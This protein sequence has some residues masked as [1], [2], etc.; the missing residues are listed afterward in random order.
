M[1]NTSCCTWI[2][3][4]GEVETQL[5]KIREKAHWLPLISLNPLSFDLSSWLPSGL[6]SWLRTILRTR[7]IVLLFILLCKPVVK[8]CPLC[9]SNLCKNDVPNKVMLSQ[10]FEMNSNAYD[11]GEI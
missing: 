2:N 10:H 9:L 11:L 7:L 8:F 1:A 6:G 4:S 5:H 3:A